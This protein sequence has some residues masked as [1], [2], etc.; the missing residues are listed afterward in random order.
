MKV[1]TA[2]KGNERSEPGMKRRVSDI[3]V[4]VLSFLVLLALSAGAAL[5]GVEDVQGE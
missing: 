3:V 1:E 5:V 2:S 4:M